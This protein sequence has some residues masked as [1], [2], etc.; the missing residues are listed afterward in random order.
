LDSFK[1]CEAAVI[2]MTGTGSNFELRLTTP[3]LADMSR[4]ERH[5]TIMAL[6]KEELSSGEIHALTIKY[7]KP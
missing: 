7:I 5:Q 3:D 6:F 4:V 1:D 2:D